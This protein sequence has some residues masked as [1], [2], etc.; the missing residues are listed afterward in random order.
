MRS[1]GGA[2]PGRATAA[3]LG[4]LAT[5]VILVEPGG[6]PE[7]L[8]PAAE[9]LLSIAGKPPFALPDAIG[10]LARRAR[11]E[12]RAFTAQDVPLQPRN[13]PAQHVDVTVTPLDEPAGWLLLELGAHDADRGTGE[14]LLSQHGAASM[15]VRAL[16]H[17]L[18]NP[19]AGLKGAA[20]L[21]GRELADTPLA[22]YVT[23]IEHESRRMESLLDRLGTPVPERSREPVNIHAVLQHVAT[24]VA[25][26]S[27]GGLNVA[28]DYDP[29]LPELEGSFD[30]L[31]QAL[32]NLARNAWQ[33][34]ATS[35]RLRTCL[36]RDTLVAASRHARVLRVDVQDDGP[37]VPPAIRPLVFFPM[38]TGRRDGSGLGLALAQSIAIRHD[39]LITFESEP[40]C[41]VFTLRIPLSN[42]RHA[43]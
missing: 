11:D 34:G 43:P 28:R 17:E 22:D 2:I 1:T 8:N 25:G 6:R 26:E 15:L 32:L 13:G 38:V 14:T 27:A 33:A 24:L 29:S 4:Q 7:Y 30:A 10:E 3:M 42:A 16:G 18:R 21:L 9:R 5:A 31:V 20:Q 39:G 12:E 35:I 23:L 37:G 41:T 40:G 19:L 36:E